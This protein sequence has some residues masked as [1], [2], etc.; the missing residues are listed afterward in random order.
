MVM[1]ARKDSK[2]LLAKIGISIF[3]FELLWSQQ[4]RAIAWKLPQQCLSPVTFPG[5][6]TFYR[7]LLLIASGILSHRTKLTF[8][9][10][11]RKLRFLLSK[12]VWK[13]NFTSWSHLDLWAENPNCVSITSLLDAQQM[14]SLLH[15]CNGFLV[16][17]LLQE[18]LS[19]GITA[20]G[21]RVCEQFFFSE[22]WHKRQTS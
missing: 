3:A 5:E 21:Q 9:Y 2:F 4:T 22:H 8:I 13:Y 19:F 6:C 12:P 14:C 1:W 7:S 11:A 17:F 16:N 10:I 15:W 20:Q 18:A